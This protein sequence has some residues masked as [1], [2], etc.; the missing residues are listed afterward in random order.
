MVAAV[1]AV[2]EA[3]VISIGA[4]VVGTTWTVTGKRGVVLERSLTGFGMGLVGS[5]VVLL[6]MFSIGCCDAGLEI[7]IT[8]ARES[9]A[10][11]GGRV[12]PLLVSIVSEREEVLTGWGRKWKGSLKLSTVA[13]LVFGGVE[14]LSVVGPNIS[15]VSL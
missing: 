2:M 3:F 5:A 8:A 12:V 13:P 4:I 15:D 6:G 10:F 9:S 11:S 7:S 14:S 1:G